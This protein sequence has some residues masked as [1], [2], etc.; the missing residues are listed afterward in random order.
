MKVVTLLPCGWYLLN[1][2]LKTDLGWISFSAACWRYGLGKVLYLLFSWE[3]ESIGNTHT[4][5]YAHKHIHILKEI[6]IKNW[7][8]DCGGW[9]WPESWNQCPIWSLRTG[10]CC[11]TKKSWCTN[12]KAINQEESA[13]QYKGC[14][15]EFSTT[16]RRVSLCSIHAFTWLNAVHP[17]YGGQCALLIYWFKS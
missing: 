17:H 2:G 1:H 4:H 3:I 6:I 16:W 14:W 15:V 10:S 12:L 13:F 9:P 7:P 8:Y 5:I 11:R